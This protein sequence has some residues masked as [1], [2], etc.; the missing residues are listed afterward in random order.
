MFIREYLSGDREACL[1]VLESNTPEFFLENDRN[2]FSA[3][4]DELPGPYFVV[5]D[6]RAESV[7]LRAV[8]LVPS[9]FAREGFR[10]VEVVPNGFGPGLDRVTMRLDVTRSTVAGS[11]TL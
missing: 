3:F 1:E 11:A 2:E 4:L 7:I 5:E 9:F 8:R 6:D 10:I